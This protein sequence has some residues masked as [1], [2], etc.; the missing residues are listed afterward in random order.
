MFEVTDRAHRE[1]VGRFLNERGVNI[2]VPE[3]QR[4]KHDII[5]GELDPGAKLKLDDL[6]QRYSASLST[7]RETLN[8]L[9]S[10]GFVE[11]A[12]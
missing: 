11:T 4:I 3:D 5:F 12:W 10:E 2:V 7:L 6:K 9:A 8:R 1:L